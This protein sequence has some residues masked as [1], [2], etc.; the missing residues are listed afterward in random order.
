[1]ISLP[2]R[3]APKSHNGIALEF[4]DCTFSSEDDVTHICQ[5]VVQQL[6]QL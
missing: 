1:M 3:R 4:I 5:V 6:N 2:G